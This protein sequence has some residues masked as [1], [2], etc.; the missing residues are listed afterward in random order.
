MSTTVSLAAKK[1]AGDSVQPIGNQVGA[2]MRGVTLVAVCGKGMASF[3]APLGVK[4][5]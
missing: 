2:T 5:N 4:C 3:S 1:A